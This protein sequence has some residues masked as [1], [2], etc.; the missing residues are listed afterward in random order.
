MKHRL[1]DRLND[2]K[3]ELGQAFLQLES[4]FLKRLLLRLAIAVID[5][6]DTKVEDLC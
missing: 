1:Y 2:K 5:K 4:S 3:K 6:S